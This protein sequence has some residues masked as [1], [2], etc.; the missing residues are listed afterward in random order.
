MF[1]NPLTFVADGRES[2]LGK[3]LGLLG[4]AAAFTAVGAILGAAIGPVAILASIIGTLGSLLVL[5]FVKERAPFNLILLYVFATF[6]GLALGVII[7]SYV[8]SGFGQVVID[9]GAT[10]ALITLGAGMYGMSTSR[11]LTSLGNILR[12]ALFTIVIAS[13]VGIFTQLPL[14]HLI[15]SIVTAVIFTGFLIIDLNRLSKARTLTN[16]DAI[17]LTINVYLDIVNLF[18]ALLRI[19]RFFAARRR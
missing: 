8:A 4:F 14:F 3:V 13:I 16:G 17:M 1:A 10:T 19:L 6:E 18:L 12:I 7:S 2:V 11:D 9:A 15:L 5:M